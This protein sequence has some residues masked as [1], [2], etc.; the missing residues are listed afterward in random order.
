MVWDAL[1][2]VP[3]T[4]TERQGE[5][6]GSADVSS[7]K[8]WQK[9]T[10][11]CL[12]YSICVRPYERQHQQRPR[13]QSASNSIINGRSTGNERRHE[14]QQPNIPAILRILD[15]NRRLRPATTD[16]NLERISSH[17]V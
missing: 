8:S 17:I 13:Q 4:R 5:V 10:S 2:R 7:G 14:E 6:E 12:L 1:A 3:C 15:N 16:L 11:R 9:K